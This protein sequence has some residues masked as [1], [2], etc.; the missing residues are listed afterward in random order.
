MT[1]TP[2]L[3]KITFILGTKQVVKT[4]TPALLKITF[5]L[6]AKQV[7]IATGRKWF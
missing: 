6:E 2:V 1:T 4:T 3:L 5:V 7:V